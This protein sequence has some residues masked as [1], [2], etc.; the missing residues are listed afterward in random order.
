MNLQRWDIVGSW[1]GLNDS[2]P[3]WDVFAFLFYKK[4]K[5]NWKNQLICR[6]DVAICNLNKR[7]HKIL[8]MGYL[9]LKIGK[10]LTPATLKY[11]QAL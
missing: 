10:D 6:S 5:Q 1:V 11:F 9:T 7:I 2:I 3:T 4:R 8:H